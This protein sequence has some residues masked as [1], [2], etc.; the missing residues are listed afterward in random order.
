MRK[1]FRATHANAEDIRISV[2]V[3]GKCRVSGVEYNLLSLVDTIT[4]EQLYL[5]LEAMKEIVAWAE[6]KDE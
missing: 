2:T 4:G 1:R 6:T 3:M 5:T